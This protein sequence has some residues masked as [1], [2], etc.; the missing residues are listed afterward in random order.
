[1]DPMDEHFEGAAKLGCKIKCD[2]QD[3]FGREKKALVTVCKQDVGS[4]VPFVAQGNRCL[5]LQ[6]IFT[7]PYW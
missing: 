7:S 2:V 4:T 1:M 5:W 6:A 3:T